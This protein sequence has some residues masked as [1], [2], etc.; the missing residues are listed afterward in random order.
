VTAENKR[1]LA[2]FV[3]AVWIERDLDVLDA[4]WTVDCV[5]HAARPGEEIGLAALR[6]YHE[7]LAT[8][9]AGFEAVTVNIIQQ[10]AEADLVVTHLITN[11]IHRGAFSGLAPTGRAVHMRTIRIDR[12][13]HRKIAEHWSLADVPGLQAQ[14]R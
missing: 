7:A 12:I 4:F 8:D 1:I 10:V 3:Q 9:F 13:A 6:R 11:G 5:N 2:E 14:L